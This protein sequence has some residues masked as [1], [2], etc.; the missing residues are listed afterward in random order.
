MPEFKV[1][2]ESLHRCEWEAN[3]LA[4]LVA[5]LPT[6]ID[7][8]VAAAE[9]ARAEVEAER[10]KLEAAEQL[11][12]AKE[13]EL[14]DCE[15][16]IAKYKSQSAQV[17]TNTEYTALLSE[18]DT[19]TR[20]ISDVEEEILL[21]MESIEEVGSRLEGFSSEKKKVEEGHLREAEGMRSRLAEAQR[22][23]EAREKEREALASGLPGDAGRIYL[24]MRTSLGSGTSAIKG[25]SCAACHRDVP[26]ETI[27]RAIA[28][29]L[30]MCAYCQRIL[31]SVKDD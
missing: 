25:R 24:R 4:R 14:A 21:A 1:A 30:Q 13:G 3:G 17:K 27:N 7:A 23:L 20:R 15:A 5:Q 6:E 22:D 9:G 31:V 26:Y 29:E 12:R 2:L 8:K 16:L 10:Q 19:V 11:R 28:G 18:I